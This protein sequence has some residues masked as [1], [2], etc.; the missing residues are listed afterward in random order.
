M[1]HWMRVTFRVVI[2]VLLVP[3]A[4]GAQSEIPPIHPHPEV[5]HDV[6]VAPDETWGRL[7]QQPHV[8]FVTTDEGFER[9]HVPAQQQ[10]VRSWS[11][12]AWRGERV[13]A[14]VLV[15]SRIPVSGLHA[16]PVS[17]KGAGGE[18]IPATAMRIRF[19]RYVLSEFPYGSHEASCEEIDRRE[20][21]LF[22]TCSILFPGSIFRRQ[23]FGRSDCSMDLSF[24]FW[25]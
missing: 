2:W 25:C 6:S 4:W 8:S 22:Q 15:W 20:F 21:T 24:S 16:V 9:H 1:E 3:V 23:L 7:D 5:E 19:V 17:L 10:E 12:I 18:T 11:A 13:H 14:Q